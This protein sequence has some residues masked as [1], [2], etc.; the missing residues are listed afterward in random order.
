MSVVKIPVTGR[1]LVHVLDAFYRDDQTQILE[2]W[3]LRNN[4]GSPVKTLLDDYN[5]MI[6]N[7]SCATLVEE[8]D[9]HFQVPERSNL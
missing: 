1:A 8:P 3:A 2:L 5:K 4:T 7:P 6:Q 9:N